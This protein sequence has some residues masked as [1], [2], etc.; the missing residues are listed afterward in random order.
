M[1]KIIFLICLSLTTLSLFAQDLV[2]LTFTGIREDDTFQRLDSVQITNLSKDWIETI[3]Y[4]DTLL[5]M[6]TLG[7]TDAERANGTAKLY[8]NT[9]NPFHGVTDFSL[10]LT[11]EEQV[12]MTIFD[13]SGKNVASLKRTLPAGEHHFRATLS[14]PQ[15]YLLGVVTKYGNA[16]IKMVNAGN[17]GKSYNLDYISSLPL[18]EDIFRKHTNY[19]FTNGDQ[20]QYIGYATQ[21]DGVKDVLL[22]GIQN[23]SD[24]IIFTFPEEI[25]EEETTIPKVTTLSVDHASG[26]AAEITSRILSDGGSEILEFGIVCGTDS[27]LDA[28]SI[29]FKAESLA[30][31]STFIT[32]AIHLTKDIKFT[33]FYVRAYARNAIGTAYGNAL[34][35]L[36]NKDFHCGDKVYD[37]EGN[38]Y[39]TIR[40][41]AQ[42]WTADNIRTKTLADGMQLLPLTTDAEYTYGRYYYEH[43]DSIIG[44]EVFYPWSTA[45]NFSISQTDQNRPLQGVCPDGWHVPSYK[46]WADMC[47]VIDPAW[48]RGTMATNASQYQLPSDNKLAIKL[49]EPDALWIHYQGPGYTGDTTHSKTPNTPGYN[50]DNHINDPD[51]NASG[52]SAKPVG[53]WKA[54]EFYYNAAAQYWTDIGTVKGIARAIKVSYY[55]TGIEHF[56]YDKTAREGHSVRCVLS[57][58]DPSDPSIPLYPA[59]E[60]D[61]SFSM[62]FL[63]DPQAYNKFD[64]AQPLFEMQT[65][66]TSLM[67]NRLNV[68]TALISGDFVEKNDAEHPY[69]NGGIHSSAQYQTDLRNGNQTSQQQWESVSRA[70]TRLDNVLPYVPCQGNH[71]CGPL[72]AEDRRSDLPK[73]IYPERNLLNQEHMVSM[74]TN[75]EGKETMENVAMEFHTDTWGDLLI[76]GFEFAPRDEALNWAKQLIESDKYKNHRVII[77]THSFLD[78]DG[79]RPT[80]ESYTLQ[81]RNW[82]QAVWEKLV[83]PSENIVMVLCGHAGSPPSIKST[84]ASTDYSCTV[85]F[86]SD[87]AANGREIPQMMFNAQMADGTWYGNGGDGWL[88]ILEFMPD[89]ETVSVRT[90]SPLFALSK[91]TKGQAWRTK[92]YDQFTFKA[93]K[94]TIDN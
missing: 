39:R 38:S 79:K 67:R 50:Y 60:N 7:I 32:Q 82:P 13:V 29:L 15:T 92:D 69:V 16:S 52:F 26:G 62:I 85:S 33:K 44:T 12:Y 58:N 37:I 66:W 36:L 73:Y 23:G 61:S 35:F 57:D 47:N 48:S 71:D 4:P 18:T 14:T 31:D 1:K 9:P 93:P 8:Q 70:L 22:T 5:I 41:G 45:C 24:T 86:R 21:T 78:K 56:S 80:S 90:F 27:I 76:I 42:C 10:V 53:Y 87:T 2:T 72:A 64:L 11:D 3:Y 88:R 94:L 6:N 59:L 51:A 75:Y 74:G 20:M 83:Y 49:T 77:F 28:N 46:E 68:L 63:S 65:A 55:Q 19:Q 17:Y 40:I 30:N 25:E 43:T 84:V 89:G 81:P 34:S 54:G 91:F